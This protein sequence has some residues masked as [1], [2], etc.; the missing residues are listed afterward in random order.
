MIGKSTYARIGLLVNCTPLEPAWRGHV[1]IELSNVGHRPIK[2]YANEGI[3]QVQFHRGK[4]PM[5]TYDEKHNAKYQ[6]QSG[7]VYPRVK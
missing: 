2:V 4:R 3:A 6:D 7:I 5:V 1:T